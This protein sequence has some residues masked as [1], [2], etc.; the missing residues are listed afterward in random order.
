MRDV[1]CGVCQGTTS[2]LVHTTSDVPSP[3]FTF[4]A[5]SSHFF[6]CAPPP[7][8]YQNF[9][10]VIPLP[11]YLPMHGKQA[12]GVV[13]SAF[14]DTT[15]VLVHGARSAP[16]LS[17]AFVLFFDEP[18]PPEVCYRRSLAHRKPRARAR[19]AS[20]GIWLVKKIEERPK[21]ELH[22]ELSGPIMP[23]WSHAGLCV[24]CASDHATPP[25]RPWFASH[26]HVHAT[27]PLWEAAH[28]KIML[29][30]VVVP[31]GNAHH[32]QHA[33]VGRRAMTPHPTAKHHAVKIS[34]API[35]TAENQKSQ[36]TEVP[37]FIG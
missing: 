10:C 28:N 16:G 32:A 4:R 15:G 17:L 31:A 22:F 2:V 21:S 27:R 20:F 18:P 26:T 11:L 36:I 3:P 5:P 23:W 37:K 13:C 24:P 14:Q 29:A 33:H 12:S 9:L 6:L 25:H 35:P 34:G 30:C 1:T 19:R 7:F 8:L